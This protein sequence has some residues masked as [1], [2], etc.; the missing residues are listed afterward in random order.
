MKQALSER[1]VLALYDSKNKTEVHTDA[2]KLGIKGIM[3]QRQAT[4]NLKPVNY[5][6]RATT[7]MEQNYYSCNLKTL[8]AVET[9]QRIKVYIL[10]VSFKLVTDCVALRATFLKKDLYP[11]VASW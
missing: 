10:G 11:R 4:G 7:L 2:S 9:I 6:S 1:L 5:Y 3:L 8:A